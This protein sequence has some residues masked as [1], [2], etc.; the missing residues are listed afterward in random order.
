MPY[1]SIFNKIVVEFVIG[2]D[3]GENGVLRVF[4]VEEEVG[5]GAVLFSVDGH[6]ALKPVPHISRIC[7]EQAKSKGPVRKVDLYI[8]MQVVAGLGDEECP[9]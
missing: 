2:Y 1:R 8:D 9:E 6:Y 7:I 3:G 4:I 5:V